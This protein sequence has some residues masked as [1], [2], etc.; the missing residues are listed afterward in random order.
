MLATGQAPFPA[1]R[2]MLVSGVLESCLTSHA[3]NQARLETPHLAVTYQPPVN[4]ITTRW[5]KTRITQNHH[6]PD[7][8]ND[9]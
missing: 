6:E 4:S 2:T 1:E 3:Q 8:Q 5:H 7:H 9:R